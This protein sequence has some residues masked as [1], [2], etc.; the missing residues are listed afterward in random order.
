[1]EYCIQAWRPYRKKD[2]D[3]LEKIQRRATKIIPE[4][5]D[6][7]YESRLLQCGLTTLETRR[8][9]GDQIEVLKMVN[10]YEDVDRNMFFKGSRTRGHN[11]A[12]VKE[13]CR[14]D[15][16]KYSFSQRVINGRNKLPNDCV[17]ASSVNMF[18]NRIDRYLIRAGY[19]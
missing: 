7:S 11:T 3:E 12:L 19:T 9:R 17:N 18:K 4:L 14:L 13:Q 2:I 5:R 8:L 10:G 15:M 6:L 1:M 16:R